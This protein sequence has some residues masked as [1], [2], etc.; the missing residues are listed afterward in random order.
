MLIKPSHVVRCDAGHRASLVYVS[1]LEVAPWNHPDAAMRYFSGLGPLLLRAA[2][3]L[4]IERGYGGRL[5]LHAVSA[6]RDFYFRLGFRMVDCPN[7][8]NEL[9]MELDESAARALL[10]GVGISK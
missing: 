1:F 7:E 4:S 6:A 3:Q 10:D 2:C 5:G 8:Y 9:Y